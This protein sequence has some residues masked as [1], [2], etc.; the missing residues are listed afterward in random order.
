MSEY[1]IGIYIAV[2]I[3]AS[4]FILLA[5][6]VAYVVG[7]R[8]HQRL[9]AGVTGAI[10]GV[11]TLWGIVYAVVWLFLDPNRPDWW[12]TLAAWLAV[13]SVPVACAGAFVAVVGRA[14]GARLRGHAAPGCPSCGRE[15]LVEAAFCGWCGSTL[16]RELSQGVT[17]S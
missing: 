17:S 15:I 6:A 7:R 14:P 5:L 4:P 13:L 9:I 8:I 2:L 10:A 16:P 1:A 3:F 12:V 11:S